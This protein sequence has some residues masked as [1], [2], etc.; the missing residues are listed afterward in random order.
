MEPVYHFRDKV[1]YL[2]LVLSG[3]F[4]EFIPKS[5]QEIENQRYSEK[6]ETVLRKYDVMGKSS[7]FNIEGNS[8]FKFSRYLDY[9]EVFGAT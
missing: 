8:V 5:F 6:E 3:R 1:V 7:Y 9:L 2:Y 4:G